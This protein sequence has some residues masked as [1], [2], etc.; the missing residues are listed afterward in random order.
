[1]SPFVRLRCMIRDAHI[2]TGSGMGSVSE[3][4]YSI[5][6]ARREDLAH[7]PAIELAAARLLAGH[8]PASVLAEV[9]SAAELE[10]ARLDGHLWVA[11]ADDRAVG[12]AHVKVLA[13]RVAHLHE[14]DVHPDHGRRGL[15][16]RLVTAVCDWAARAQFHA[17]TLC[18]FRD[19]P[20]NRPFYETLGFQVVPND[21]L[22]SALAA[23]VD[24]ETRRGLDPDRRVV[25][26]RV[27]SEWKAS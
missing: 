25:M 26:R 1:M 17:V 23:V 7:L 19:V 3:P 27:L 22:S 9:T 13:P 10:L 21:A 6:I 18:T 20:W 16:R 12:F 15:G 5:A 2:S 8:A 14:L 4:R 24:D 11:R